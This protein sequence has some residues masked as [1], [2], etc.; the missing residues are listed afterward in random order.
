MKRARV[1]ALAT[2]LAGLPAPLA[3]AQQAPPPPAQLANPSTLPSRVANYAWDQDVLR[4]SFSFWDI[5]D[6]AVRKKLDSGLVTNVVVSAYVFEVGQSTP[7]GVA[8]RT[9][10]VSYDLWE[11]IYRMHISE[12][13]RDRDQP[14]VSFDAVVRNCFEA[15]NLPVARRPQLTAGQPYFL[16]VEV[17]V[18]PVSRETLEQIQRWIARPTGNRDI[19]SGDALFGGFVRLFVNQIGRSEKTLTF[20]TQSVTP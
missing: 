6:P 8:L 14:G 20:R 9:C 5:I 1:F 10:A 3:R 15:R 4:A 13:E 11:D 18:N 2:M 19:S 16:G 12:P 17:D 7:I